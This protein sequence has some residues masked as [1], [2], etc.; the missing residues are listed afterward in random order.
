M[1]HRKA[2]HLFQFRSCVLLEPL[3]NSKSCEL[4]SGSSSARPLRP[5]VFTRDAWEGSVETHI[6]LSK[7]RPAQTDHR[8]LSEWSAIQKLSYLNDPPQN[9]LPIKRQR[10][11][12]G[13]NSMERSGAI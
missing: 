1:I 4:H 6:G 13:M 12:P 2:S 3:I 7:W 8:V 5:Y 11:S 9:V 10:H